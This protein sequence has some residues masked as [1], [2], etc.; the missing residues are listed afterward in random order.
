MEL[1]SLKLYDVFSFSVPGSIDGDSCSWY[2]L[3]RRCSSVQQID[4]VGNSQL[5]RFCYTGTTSAY[6]PNFAY[7]GKSLFYVCLFFILN[8]YQRMKQN[9][10]TNDKTNILDN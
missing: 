5:G 2:S 9:G 7:P 1:F 6:V 10:W 3:R 4:T 8:R